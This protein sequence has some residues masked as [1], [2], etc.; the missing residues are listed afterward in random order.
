[1]RAIAAGFTPVKGT[2]HL[3]Y[4]EIVLAETGPVGDRLLCLVDVE[5]RR[6]VRTVQHPELMAVVARREGRRLDVTLPS[7]VSVSEEPRPSGTAYTCDYWGR[8]VPL[9]LLDGP[10]AELFSEHLG[11]PVRL[12]AAPP[13][14]VVF[15][16]PATL[17]GTAS[18]RDLAERAGHPTL[19]EEAARFRATLVVETEE[20]YVEDTWLGRE[21]AV[22]DARLRVGPGVGRCAL[23]DADPET[24]KRGSRLLRTL[25]GY[26]PRNTAGEPLLAVYA[27]VATPGRVSAAPSGQ[28][29]A[30]SA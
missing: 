20:P 14:G 9:D 12:A 25:A 10:H 23:I 19:P 6:V 1:V 24:G 15:S 5:A 26:R 28:A 21:I 16:A 29:V 11:R 17:I 3:T 27:E 18:L 30:P 7:G 22:G 8:D 4:D 13:G 2:R